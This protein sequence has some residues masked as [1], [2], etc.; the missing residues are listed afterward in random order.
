MRGPV[1]HDAV[2]VAK[3]SETF[4]C[5]IGRSDPSEDVFW[6]S[7]GKMNLHILAVWD[8]VSPREFLKCLPV[9]WSPQCHVDM[10]R[11]Q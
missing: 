6:N 5:E 2:A 1:R 8:F 10:S 9:P 7:D 4:A 11:Y 3:A